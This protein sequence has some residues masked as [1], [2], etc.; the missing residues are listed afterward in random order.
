MWGQTERSPVLAAPGS[1]NFIGLIASTSNQTIGAKGRN[2][3]ALSEKEALDLCKKHKPLVLKLAAE[4]RGKGIEFEEL[5]AAGQL[6]LA[7]A[8]RK[9]DPH[10]G[11]PFGAYARHWIKGEIT[12]LFKK[13]ARNPLAKADPIEDWN[14]KRKDECDESVPAL[15]PDLSKL[16]PKERT[17]VE[18]RSSG[19][20]LRSVGDELDLSPERVRQIETKAVAR[21]RKGNIALVCIRDLTRRR[22][23]RKPP[24]KLLPF[25]SV[26]YTCRTYS[27]PE[28]EAYERG[29]L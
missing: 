9:F 15:G 25:R 14:E 6:G 1:N 3:Q 19:Q 28:I 7:H 29:E 16:T 23:Y 5:E 13:T 17:V 10:R 22:G 2:R 8:L 11:T 18:A 20:S 26:K 4:Q 12:A 21:L 27:R 24:K